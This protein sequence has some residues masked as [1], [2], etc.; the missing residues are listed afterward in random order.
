MQGKSSFRIS[1]FRPHPL[2]KGGQLQTIAGT[3]LPQEIPAIPATHQ[4]TLDLS[5]EDGDRTSIVIDH[6][7]IANE[8]G[9][10]M[11]VLFHGLSGNANSG[12]NLRISDKFR[13]L[14][15]TVARYFHRGTDPQNLAIAEKIYHCGSHNDIAAALDL[16]QTR[17]PESRLFVV[18]F[19]LSG[20]ALLNL[21]GKEHTSL[22]ARFPKL[23]SALAVCP[24]LDLE[25]SSRHLSRATNILF[26][27]YFSLVL[28]KQIKTKEK[29][30]ADL[31]RSKI[32]PWRG[33]RELDESYTAKMG[34]FRNRAHYY[35]TSSAVR[36]LDRIT[37]PTT[38]LGAADD[39]IV[40]SKAYAAGTNNPMVNIL[41]SPS[42]GHM[43]FIAQTPTTL[44]D[45]R[46]MDE[47][48]LTWAISTH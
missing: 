37:L 25:H 8:H 2:F 3:F 16:I 30:I 5:F 24:P 21:L 47:F 13:R 43:G 18:G 1:P 10:S 9:K 26:D 44:G 12:Y 22:A 48:I 45:H 28:T 42:G 36:V 17:Y 11:I 34:G 35:E 23:K 46:W 20:A 31:P 29:L 15:F 14:G 39:P 27:R 41:L 33:L 32:S 4:N 6:P 40:C 7:T 38:I 19:S